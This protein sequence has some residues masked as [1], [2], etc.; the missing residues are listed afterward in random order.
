MPESLTDG[1]AGFV[2]LTRAE[3][4]GSV[5]A[6]FERIAARAP[7]A[8]AIVWP[9]GELTYGALNA[10]A[11]RLARAI[12]GRRGPASA[13]V[14]VLVD[15]D[16]SAVVS[17]LAALKA[18]KVYLALEASHPVAR[19]RAIVDDAGADLVVAAARRLEV[20]RALTAAPDG[21]LD[22][23]AV[24]SAA[25]GGDP[26]VPLD[27]R[28]AA[29]LGYTSGST[30]TPK[31]VL[32]DHR[33][34]LHR[35]R[36]HVN[37]FRLGPGDRLSLVHRPSV[38]A[39]FRHMWGALLSGAT[40]MP[41]DL[42]A[43]GLEGFGRWLAASGITHCHV[44]ASRVPAFRRGAAAR[45]EPARSAP[46]VGRQRAG[47]PERRRPLPRALLTAMPV[48]ERLRP[49]R[50]RH[51]AG[52][53]R[54]RGHAASRRPAADRL[55][56]GR[57]GGAAPRRGPA[58]GGGSATRGRSR[59][60]ASF[61]PS[62][63]GAGRTWT[64][65]RSC[66]IPRAAGRASTCPE[67]SA[68]CEA[69]GCLTLLGRKDAQ[70]KLRGR[71]VDPL[72][73][74]RR[75][76][77]HPGLAGA[78]VAVRED[79]PGDQRL[80]AYVVAAPGAAPTVREL[81]AFAL[82]RLPEHLVPSLWV[83]LP[84]LPRSGTGKVARQSLPAPGRRRPDLETA[85]VAPR[86]PIERELS[87]IWAD[88]LGLDEIGIHDDFLE[89]GGHSLLAAS[90]VA[91][92]REAFGVDLPAAALLEAPRVSGMATV[93]VEHLLRT[94]PPG[95]GERLLDGLE[96]PEARPPRRSARGGH[97]RAGAGREVVPQPTRC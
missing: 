78:A 48:R 79:R 84:A 27:G 35:V 23:D 66:P 93:I 4:E 60:G 22:A 15:H 63:T 42:Q 39:S 11:N 31:G 45:R 3:L 19:L 76:L 58:P 9:E 12:L 43:E 38:S 90:L 17:I 91:R 8:P 62:A 24:D 49:H 96:A 13:P 44:A 51:R 67:T 52:L 71:F 6:L 92:V 46:R 77:E 69:D 34:I 55:P 70:P 41:Y 14:V 26:A 80:V 47:A 83:T 72:E 81:R 57:Q 97:R 29:F 82:E 30:G 2:E 85:L 50:G 36:E 65:R 53:R 7:D 28:A 10:A 74:E 59:S 1:S 75:L 88:A 56:A 25:D 64:A 89:L 40:L 18:G 5:P 95:A 87:R 68:G 20:A 61:S 33:G 16:A 21:A 73:V 94:L 37:A 54:G 32:W 86:S